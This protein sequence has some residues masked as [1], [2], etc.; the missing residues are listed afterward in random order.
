MFEVSMAEISAILGSVF[1]LLSFAYINR[2]ANAENDGLFLLLNS[3]AAVFMLY[4]LIEFWNIGVLIN[5]VAW[6]IISFYS[7]YRNVRRSRA[8]SAIKVSSTS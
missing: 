4:S 3:I 6:I 5:N 1:F 2:K 8:L 7:F